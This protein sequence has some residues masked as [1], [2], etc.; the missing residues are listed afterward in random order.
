VQAALGA[1]FSTM[2]VLGETLG[3]LVAQALGA[4]A[5]VLATLGPPAQVLIKALGAAL[6]PII[7]ALGPVLLS[8]AQAVGKLVIA[9]S[10]L[11]GVAGDLIAQLLPILVP[12]LDLLTGIF[13][14]LAGPIKQIAVAL[15][16]AL[17][18]VIKG[19]STVV[20]DLVDRYLDVF[21][22]LLGD[23]APLIP[24]LTPVLIQLGKSFGQILTAV[25]PLLPQLATMTIMFVAQLLPA[26]LPLVPPLLQLA[27]ML[28]ELATGVIVTVVVP[29]LQGLIDFMTGLQ[30]GFQPA[31]D[32]VKWLTTGIAKLF[33]W[34]SDHLVGHSVIPDMVRSIVSWFAG[35]P[36]KAVAAL[37]NIASRLA[38]VMVNATNRMI[39]AVITGLK[40]IVSWMRDLPGR[41]KDALGDLGS[42][43]YRSGQAL[44]KGFISGITSMIKPVKNAVGSV[45]SGA[46]DMFP[47]SPARE[48]PFSG[49]GWV[50]YSGQAIGDGLAAGMLARAA[51]VARAAETLA[52]GAA[53]ALGMQPG[54]G[55]G[56]LAVAGGVGGG[57]AGGGSQ[58][59]TVRVVVEG[60]EA[61]KK[62]I[63][64]IVT[65]TAGGG[66]NSVQ[67]T[68]G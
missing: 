2:R 8:A 47:F 46:R 19:L 35:L 26:I 25:A 61:V 33:E 30:R 9:L 54:A 66:P 39:G 6:G 32:A 64:G 42:Y 23:L 44:L 37:G 20:Q 50:E 62:L 48:G 27:T 40:A 51:H 18:P 3:P 43:L 21:L 5:P 14:D 13:T 55:F 24:Q 41:A 58:Q 63:R 7:K 34:L 31:I 12:V 16:T 38:G 36:G 67:R 28:L 10:P 53:D 52:G 29:A 56:S 68:F 57:F 60:P 1:L 22:D 4:L 59:V 49:R 11:I 45:L 15:G 65:S 17:K